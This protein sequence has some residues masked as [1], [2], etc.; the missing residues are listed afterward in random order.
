MKSK[1]DYLLQTSGSVSEVAEVLYPVSGL[2]PVGDAGNIYN[3]C[4]SEFHTFQ[5]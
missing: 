1:Y 2:G 4:K 5:E 3:L